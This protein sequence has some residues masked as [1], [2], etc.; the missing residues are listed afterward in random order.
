MK[1]LF[2]DTFYYLALFN[3]RDRAHQK[4]KEL[5]AGF[6]GRVLTTAWILMELADG[7]A[8]T[9]QRN[10]FSVF[11]EAMRADPDVRITPFSNA[12]FDEAVKLYASRP[13]KAWS[14][15]DC[16]SFIVMEREALTEALTGDRHF[17]Q[18]GYRALLL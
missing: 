8:G 15:T 12:L 1:T 5:T 16:T 17:E 10:A 4:A 13:D 18:A 9:T 14:L 11:L 7:M 6:S 2:A 3:T